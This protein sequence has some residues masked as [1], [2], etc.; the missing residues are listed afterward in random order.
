[1]TFHQKRSFVERYLALRKTINPSAPYSFVQG[2]PADDSV[3]RAV[4]LLA[5]K[6][7]SEIPVVD[8]SGRPVGLVDITDVIGLLPV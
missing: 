6:N 2:P 1:M 3:V 8:E 5:R 7:I 4:E